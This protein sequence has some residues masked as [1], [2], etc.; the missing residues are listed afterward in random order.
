[1]SDV[2][3]WALL[4]QTYTP[5]TVIDQAS[6]N[7]STGPYPPSANLS[8]AVPML[9]SPRVPVVGVIIV[10]AVLLLLEHRRLR[11]SRR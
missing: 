2:S 5:G 7:G 1:M 11:L 9:S 4:A 8:Q 6:Q 3:R 10:V